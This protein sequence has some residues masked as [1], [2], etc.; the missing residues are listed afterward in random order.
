MKSNTSKQ[1]FRLEDLPNIGTRIANDLRLIGI[2]SPDDLRHRDPLVVYN[3][4]KETM[5]PRHD[6]CVFY[7]LLSVAHFF[8]TLEHVSWWKFTAAGKAELNK[9]NAE[10]NR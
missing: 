4:L 7:T 3:N 5:G 1:I 10:R 2:N 8:D 6:P 9:Q